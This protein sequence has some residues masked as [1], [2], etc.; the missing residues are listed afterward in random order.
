MPCPTHWHDRCACYNASLQYTTSIT[1]TS[2][3]GPQAG[4]IFVGYELATPLV[5][6]SGAWHPVESVIIQP[7]ASYS[8]HET[9]QPDYYHLPNTYETLPLQNG[10]RREPH[11]Y[12]QEQQKQ[13]PLSREQ[14]RFLTPNVPSQAY[15]KSVRDTPPVPHTIHSRRYSSSHA[16]QLLGIIGTV[17]SYSP[18]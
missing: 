8:G 10:Y 3:F 4:N 13:A 7:P 2:Q 12:E 9:S 1:T 5:A 14:V 16:Q 17:A 15:T 11:V 6:T 18:K